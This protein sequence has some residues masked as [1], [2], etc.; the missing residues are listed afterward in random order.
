[1]SYDL[2]VFQKDSAPGNRIDFMKWYQEQIE[3]KESHD[4]NDPINTS[5]ELRNWFMEMIKTFP[6][7]NGP[8]ATK[9][10]DSSDASDYAIG[11]EVIYVGFS[12]SVADEARKAMIRLAEKYQVGFFDVSNNNPEI[13]FPVNGKLVPIGNLDTKKTS[14]ISNISNAKSKS[15]WKFWQH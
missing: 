7:L 5:E 9:D 6:P 8:L 12:W 10:F 2:M 1:M 3:W 11:N 13:Y 15:W 4:Y 14:N